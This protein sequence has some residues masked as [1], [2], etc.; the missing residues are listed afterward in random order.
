MPLYGH[1]T[2]SSLFNDRQLLLLITLSRLVNKVGKTVRIK[3]DAHYAA[4][5]STMLS[6]AVGKVAD[7][8]TSIC[9]WVQSGGFVG[10]TF[11]QGQCLPMKFDFAESV[12]L[13]GFSGSWLGA[14]DWG[15]R[16]IEREALSKMNKGNVERASAASHPLPDDSATCMVTDP[17]YYNAVP[18]ADL[19]DFFYVWHRRTLKDTH[20][21]LFAS[22]LAPKADEI[23][24]MAGW[25]PVRYANKT[26]TFFENEISKAFCE[27]RRVVQRSGIGVI[28]FAHKTTTG[29]ESLLQ[30]IIQSGWVVTASW[31]VD[32]ERGSRLRAMQ[33]AASRIIHSHCRSS[34]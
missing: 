2:W 4:A 14:I 34:A 32:T 7:Y 17:P 28:V 31:P 23:C 10:H 29:W 16:I 33:S 30:A 13:A 20:G 9:T 22:D 26:A 6:L 25:D 12:P 15:C 18:Y 27:A 3:E 21:D 11:A 1:N 19:S 5:I 8:S 24:E